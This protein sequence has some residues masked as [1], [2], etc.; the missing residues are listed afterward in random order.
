MNSCGA[1]D[2]WDTAFGPADLVRFAH[3]GRTN[4]TLSK[5]VFMT[6][7]SKL[8]DPERLRAVRDSHLLDSA[9]E[10]D[11][12]QLTRMAARLMGAPSAFITVL[13]DQRQFLK[14]AVGTEGT[15]YAAGNS[16]S[17]DISFCKHVV[18]TSEP[19]V[20]ENAREHDLVR[21]N[22]GVDAGVIAYAG[23]PLESPNGQAIGALCVVDSKPREWSED[24][25]RSLRAL[26]RSAMKLMEQR[27]TKPG[28]Q[29]EPRFEKGSGLVRCVEQHIQAVDEY[30]ELIRR[31][32]L[33]DFESEAEAQTKVS[34]S[35]ENLREAFDRE[36]SAGPPGGT[37]DILFN[38][39][40][41]YIA[42]EDVRNTTAREFARGQ[43]E[44]RKLE[45][46]IATTL[47]S[48][49]ALR[50]AALNAGADL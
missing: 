27:F 41:S 32:A 37:D 18:A 10:G 28:E 19:L 24:D 25:I 23:I 34:Y 44:L 26:A 14:S 7:L 3:L 29:N 13:D 11:F 46:A 33:P 39:I 48:T 49:D 38:R 21:D 5:A 20:V 4:R 15:D 1:S 22:K 16:T 36:A 45:I 42:A 2:F 40:G 6:D 50:V 17:L 9:A 30:A 8:S 47:E 35:F 43:A 12:D 31:K